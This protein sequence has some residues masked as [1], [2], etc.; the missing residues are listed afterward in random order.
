MLTVTELLHP[1]PSPL[2]RLVKQA[3]YREYGLEL[4][5]T[6]DT[7]PVALGYIAG[8]RDAAYGRPPSRYSRRVAPGVL[9]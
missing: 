8:L 5:V 7:A 1:A 9:R 4:A 2:W 6:E 3:R